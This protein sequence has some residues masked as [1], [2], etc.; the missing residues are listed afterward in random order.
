M[1]GKSHKFIG[2]IAGGAAAYYGITKPGGDVSYLFYIISMPV[3]AMIADIDHDSSK[4]GRTRKKIMA[5]V[6]TVFASLAIVA[7]SFFLADAHKQGQ[8]KFLY[9]ILTVLMVLLP[10]L[11]ISA[12]AKMDFIQKNLKFMVKHRGLMHTLIIPAF[13]FAATFF[14]SEPTFKILVTGLMVGYAT[15]LFSDM[16]TSMGCPIFFP[17]TKKNISIMGIKTGSAGEY[18]AAALLS[19]CL[20]ALFA[21]GIIKI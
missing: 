1:T 10:F 9:A 18:I 3:G 16:L 21:F 6:S 15:H 5:V 13:M 4:L 14:I 20:G 17:L 7:V 19:V 8:E 2:L 11:I 12:F